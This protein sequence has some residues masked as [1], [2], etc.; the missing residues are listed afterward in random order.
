MSDFPSIAPNQ[1]NYDLGRLNI[2]EV[3][4]F[5]GPIRFRHSFQVNGN[6]F[7]LS[8][9]GLDQAQVET[10]RAHYTENGGIHGYFIVP[11]IA[12]G[13]YAAVAADSLYRYSEPPV[14][15]H[16]GLYYNLEVN[17]RIVTGTNLLYLLAG[18]T[19]SNRTI[20]DYETYT[21]LIFN[22]VAPFILNAGAANPSSPAATLILQGGGASQ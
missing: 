20:L 4:T 9:R 6:G 15:S 12:W 5:A 19:A 22:G 1:I 18:G 3:Q 13:R 14:E 16:E 21:S 8:Y 11:S 17:L 2:G 7:R 10:F